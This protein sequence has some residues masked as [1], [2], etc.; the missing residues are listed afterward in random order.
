MTGVRLLLPG[1]LGFKF[2]P[3]LDEGAVEKMK[4][5]KKAPKPP[6]LSDKEPPVATR[7]MAAEKRCYCSGLCPPPP[8]HPPNPNL[9]P[10]PEHPPPPAGGAIISLLLLLWRRR[11]DRSKSSRREAGLKNTR[12]L[13]SNVGGGA[14]GRGATP[15]PLSPLPPPACTFSIL[16]W[17]RLPLPP[18]THS[19]N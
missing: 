18:Q 4:R 6:R 10:P 7:L 13:A 3:K 5:E 12:T 1:F 16:W 19:R 15:P 17:L 2:S 9:T 14:V 8:L 11:C